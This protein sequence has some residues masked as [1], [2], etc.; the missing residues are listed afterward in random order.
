VGHDG[1]QRRKRDAKQQAVYKAV[2]WKG[3]DVCEEE[4]KVLL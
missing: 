3:E 4:E 1:S 2:Q